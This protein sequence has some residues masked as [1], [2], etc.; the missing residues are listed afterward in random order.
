MG[1]KNNRCV[2]GEFQR[3]H[4]SQEPGRL[5]RQYF[6]ADFEPTEKCGD[7]MNAAAEGVQG[8]AAVVL[9]EQKEYPF[10]LVFDEG[11]D[12]HDAATL[13]CT[14]F[15]KALSKTDRAGLVGGLPP[16]DYIHA[17]AAHSTDSTGVVPT[18][19]GYADG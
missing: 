2:L 16:I 17:M 4:I 13:W 12:I 19:Y 7:V 5:R 6:W 11:V 14:A 18:R 9:T 8:I 15:R 1:D 10:A 3:K